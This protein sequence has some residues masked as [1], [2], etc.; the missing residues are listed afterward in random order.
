MSERR[1]R[2]ETLKAQRRNAGRAERERLIGNASILQ[3]LG[4]LVGL[5]EQAPG[6][7]SFELVGIDFEGDAE[8]LVADG[9]HSTTIFLNLAGI[10]ELLASEL[11]LGEVS[12][13]TNDVLDTVRRGIQ[14]AEASRSR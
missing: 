12:S 11:P 9:A 13:R 7:A 4:G 5:L 8:L 3:D 14:Q 10:D 2:Y 1:A 6:T